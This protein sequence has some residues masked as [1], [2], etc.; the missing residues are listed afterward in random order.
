ME[1]PEINP[2]HLQLT[3][4]QQMQQEQTQEKGTFLQH[5]AVE[6]LDIHMQKKKGRP[7]SSL[8]TK[9]NSK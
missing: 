4:F 5:R 3:D 6:K 9:I 1:D 2:S 8:Y 7:N